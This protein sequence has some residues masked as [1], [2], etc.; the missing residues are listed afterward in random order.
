MYAGYPSPPPLECPMSSTHCHGSCSCA[1]LWIALR[2][3]LKASTTLPRLCET[4]SPREPSRK[5]VK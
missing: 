1:A 3:Q 2:N 4:T 5:A